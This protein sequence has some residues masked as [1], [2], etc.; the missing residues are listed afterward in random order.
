MTLSLLIVDPE[1][2][3][4][5]AIA[6]RLNSIDGI[7]VVQQAGDFHE[8]IRCLEKKNTFPID[9]VVLEI[10]LPGPSGF[11]LINEIRR[12]RFAAKC[13]ALSRNTGPDAVKRALLAGVQGYV[14]KQGEPEDL[15]NAINCCR[16]DTRFI[17]PQLCQVNEIPAGFFSLDSGEEFEDPL[18][19]LSPRE[20]EV[21]HLLAKGMQN[22]AIAKKLF[23]S[24]RT[25]ETHRAR[26]TQ[27]LQLTSSLEVIRYAY[28]HG[29]SI[30]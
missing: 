2:I 26:I 16:S 29:L 22:S 19:A 1:V 13:I 11:E 25:V 27:K 6:S 24:R 10:I 17:P 15:I 8:A 14:F 20:R 4:R 3:V 28:K 23:I 7:S 30:E 12:R 5:H 18:H 21:F 9:V